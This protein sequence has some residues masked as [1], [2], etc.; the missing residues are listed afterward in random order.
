LRRRQR[1]ITAQRDPYG[2]LT[3]GEL[4]L[5]LRRFD[6]DMRVVMPG[7]VQVW[8]EVHEAHLDIFAPEQGRAQTSAETMR[9]K[10]SSAQKT[11]SLGASPQ[12]PLARTLEMADDGDPDAVLMVR[13][14]GSPDHD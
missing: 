2:P 11:G 6:P 8:T 7:E 9:S 10:G 12:R 3:V 4:I 14:F 13:L 5:Q 1:A